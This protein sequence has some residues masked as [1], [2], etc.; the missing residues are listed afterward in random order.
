MLKSLSFGFGEAGGGY[1]CLTAI[2]KSITTDT[3]AV[4][5]PDQI[6]PDLLA[7][8]WLLS[9]RHPYSSKRTCVLSYTS[10]VL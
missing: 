1:Q 7:L 3:A 9:F 8:S 4:S 6:P 5:Y 10:K 2:H